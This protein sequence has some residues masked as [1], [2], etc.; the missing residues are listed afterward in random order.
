MGWL[1]V[2]LAFFMHLDSRLRGN[3]HYSLGSLLISHPAAKAGIWMVKQ[4]LKRLEEIQHLP[5]PDRN[6][7]LLTIDNFITATKL[8]TL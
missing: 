8:K 1:M 7:L 6:S 2:R 3:D 4:T 5:E